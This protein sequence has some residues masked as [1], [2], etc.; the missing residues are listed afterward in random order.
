MSYSFGNLSMSA[1]FP[2]SDW[3]QF[4]KIHAR[5]L[6]RYCAGVLEELARVSRSAEGTA[7][8]RYLRAY[9]LMNKRDEEIAKAFNDYRRSTAEMQLILMRRMGL[10]SDEDL[11]VFSEPTQARVRA[12]GSL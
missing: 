7:H 6:E 10:L 5:L 2:E 1:D 8:E 3:R 4:K 9:K 11:S 12:I